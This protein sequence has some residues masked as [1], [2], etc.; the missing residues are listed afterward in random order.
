M[1]IKSFR[2]PKELEVR[3]RQAAERRGMRESEFV[4]EA[5]ERAVEAEADRGHDL[6]ETI[7][8]VAIEGRG[9]PVAHRAHEAAADVIAKH[10]AR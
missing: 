2:I 4:R 3:V 1:A 6:V 5:L 9:E 10:V 7:G 8:E